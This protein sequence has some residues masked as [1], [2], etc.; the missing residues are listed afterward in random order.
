MAQRLGR[1]HDRVEEELAVLEVLRRLFLGQWA[2]AVGEG[3]DHRVRAVGVG[4][5]IAA[6]VRGADLEPRIAVE[7]SLEDQVRERDGGL[8]RIADRVGEQPVAAQPARRFELAC[9][10]RMQED[11]RIELL[12]L[13]PEWMEAGMR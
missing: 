6:A 10:S 1:E 8:Q 9:A 3:A 11:Q 13:L 7:R 2:D 12:A 5:E 4:A